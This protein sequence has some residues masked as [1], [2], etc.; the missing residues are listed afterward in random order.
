M[1]FRKNGINPARILLVLFFDQNSVTCSYALDFY[2]TPEEKSCGQPVSY[3]VT[4][5]N[6]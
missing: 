5:P 1:G 4:V 2:C 6:R 3:F